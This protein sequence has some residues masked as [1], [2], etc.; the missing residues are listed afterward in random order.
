MRVHEHLQRHPVISIP[1]AAEALGL[2]QPTVTSCLSRMEE[3]G[4]VRELTGK[5]T[6]RLFAY[7]EYLDLLSEGTE[8]LRCAREP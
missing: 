5:K 2:S 1:K 6:W 4:L 3:L 7:R 8:P